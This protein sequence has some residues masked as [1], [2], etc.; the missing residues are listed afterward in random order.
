[1]RVPDQ[2]TDT[3]VREVKNVEKISSRDASQIADDVK[4]AKDE[5]KQATLLTRDSTDVSKVQGLIDSGDLTHNI[6]PNISNEGVLNLNGIQAAGISVAAGA[7]TN[8]VPQIGCYDTAGV[9][10]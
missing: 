7:A 1:M 4:F 3:A 10:H 8:C 9:S 2:I 6:I 5:G